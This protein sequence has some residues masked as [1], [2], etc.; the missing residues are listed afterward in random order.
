MRSIF[1]ASKGNNEK[2]LVQAKVDKGLYAEFRE[3]KRY[4][5]RSVRSMFE[6]FMR[7]EL[8]DYKLEMSS[9]RGYSNG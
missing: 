7:C 3:L 9:K 8:G 2:Q 1:G 5:D 6:H 4:R